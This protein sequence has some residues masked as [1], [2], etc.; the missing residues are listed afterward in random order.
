[1]FRKLI[2]SALFALVLPMACPTAA[3]AQFTFG[4][5]AAINIAGAALPTC[6]DGQNSNYIIVDPVSATTCVGGGT[7]LFADL[8]YCVC[9]KNL[10]QWTVLASTLGD[11]TPQADSVFGRT[12]AVVAQANDYS[13]A[14]VTGGIA[15]STLASMAAGQGATL[16]GV[17][18]AAGNFVGANVETVLAELSAS[19]GSITAGAFSTLPANGSTAKLY[20]VTDCIDT[21]CAAGGGSGP[22]VLKN[23]DGSAWVN[24][25]DAAK[26]DGI[27]TAATAD[28]SNAEIETAYNAQ[29]GQVSAGE[30]AA[31]TE[32]TVRRFSPDNVEAM[33]AAHGGATGPFGEMDYTDLQ[34][35]SRVVASGSGLQKIYVSNADEGDLPLG[36]DS[37]PGTASFPILTLDKARDLANQTGRVWVLLDSED[38]WANESVCTAANT[39][40]TFCTALNTGTGSLLEDAAFDLLDPNATANEIGI[41]ISST[42]PT[43]IKKARISCNV[44]STGGQTEIFGFTPTSGDEG[45]I[46]IENIQTDTCVGWDHYVT[47]TDNAKFVVIGADCSSDA[48]TV[49]NS[50]H[51]VVMKGSGTGITIGGRFT[52]EDDAVINESNDPLSLT[53]STSTF[54]SPKF[55]DF[56]SD[57]DMEDTDYLAFDGD[58]MRVHANSEALFIGSVIRNSGENDAAGGVLMVDIQA[59]SANDHPRFTA[60][61]TVIGMVSNDGDFDDVSLAIRPRATLAS[62]SVS[63]RLIQSTF[64]NVPVA[65]F[66]ASV[67]DSASILAYGRGVLWDSPPTVAADA[68]SYYLDTSGDEPG[69]DMDFSKSTFDDGEDANVNTREWKVGGITKTTC[70]GALAER[71]WTNLFDSCDAAY[72]SDDGIGTAGALD[73]DGDQFGGMQDQ[74]IC[75]TGEICDGGFPDIYSEAFPFTIPAFLLGREMSSLTLGG[76]GGNIGAR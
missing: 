39:P 37:N 36:D 74:A 51:C 59:Q 48:S 69:F 19:G 14:Q 63:I 40:Y 76:V 21:A 33:I 64:A 53:E 38:V 24:A 3:V 8:N 31:G 9:D 25:A 65:I 61:R 11:G 67:H 50:G 16:I 73:N 6:D 22:W 44:A 12:G 68:T 1:M 18:D 13:I 60:I 15:G 45:W 27:E 29:V 26:L 46:V 55:I 4:P 62:Q 23:W 43:G 10:D 41:R 54:N 58:T 17:E 42:D 20:V 57:W 75:A 2:T 47:T 34:T 72:D 32:A 35:L 52:S 7:P 28:Q 66:T 49:D 56:F 30:I 70:A 5:G 71:T